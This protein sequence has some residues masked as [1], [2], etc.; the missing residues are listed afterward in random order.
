MHVLDL[1]ILFFKKR[2]S[3]GKK[4]SIPRS[5]GCYFFTLTFPFFLRIVVKRVNLGASPILCPLDDF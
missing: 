5:S 4:K 2:T 3:E 1:G